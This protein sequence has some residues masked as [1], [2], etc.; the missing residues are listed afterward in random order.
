MAHQMVALTVQC[1]VVMKAD[2]WDN[3]LVYEMVASM[4]AKMADWMEHRMVVMLV[5]MSVDDL[6]A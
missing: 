1:W 5:V 3:A 4:V 2:S 6:D